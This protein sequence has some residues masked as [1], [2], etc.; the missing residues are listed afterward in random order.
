[1]RFNFLWFYYKNRT[2]GGRERGRRV[3]EKG[4]ER[5]GAGEKMKDFSNGAYSQGLV[6]WQ[7]R[8]VCEWRWE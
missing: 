4:E 8:G 5:M 1:M 2:R 7:L 6:L 3:S